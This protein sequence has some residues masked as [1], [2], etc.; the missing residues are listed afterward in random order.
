M[1]GNSNSPTKFP[2]IVVMVPLPLQGH[3]NQ[4]LHLSR[5][6]S[7]HH[8]PVHFVSTS[9]HCRQAN[10]RVQGWDPLAVGAI[11]FH[12]FETPPIVPTPPNPSSNT[13]FP[14]HFQTICESTTHLRDPVASL[15]REISVT[16]RRLVVIHDSL[17]GSV[18]QDFVTLPNAESYTFHSVSAFTICLY[19]TKTIQNEL[20]KLIEPQVVTKDHLSFEGFTSEFKRFMNTQHEYAKLSS[21]RIYNSCTIVEQAMLDLLENE[22][23]KRNKKLWALGPFNPVDIKRT[24]RE[25][26]NGTNYECLKWLDKQETSSV[27]FVSFGTTTS[28]TKEQ[29]TELAIGLEKSEKKFIWAFRDADKEDVFRDYNT[30][31]ELPKGYEDRIKGRGLVV[32]EWAPQLEILSHKATGGFMSHCGWN[33]CMES[34]SMGVPI[35]AWPMHSDQPTNAVLVTSI[36]KVGLTVKDW[37]LRGKMVVAEDVEKAVRRLMGTNEGEEIRRRAMEMGEGVRESVMEGGVSLLQLQSFIAHI[38]R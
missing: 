32:R 34:I 26:N 13:N 18:V 16:T 5:L 15:L 25:D 31:V 12:E 37:E 11:H 23:R 36:L 1:I 22:E 38:T 29:I 24:T 10:H 21:G 20:A 4:L 7:N 14:S 17:M 33:S 2:A 6:I 30:S 28:F 27:I 9:T 19:T 8:I 3:L 35:I